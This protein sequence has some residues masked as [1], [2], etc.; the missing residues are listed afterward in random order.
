MKTTILMP[1][2]LIAALAAACGDKEEPPATTGGG[3]IERTAAEATATAA[4]VPE[5]AALDAEE[6][7]ILDGLPTMSD[8]KA[9]A[10]KE[11]SEQ[12]ADAVLAEIRKELGGGR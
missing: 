5:A 7:R 6:Q 12:N 10:E 11:I 2:V 8:A 3:A 1:L 9:A 4:G